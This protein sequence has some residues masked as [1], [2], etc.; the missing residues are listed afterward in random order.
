M[1]SQRQPYVPRPKEVGKK[2]R[3]AISALENG[4]YQIIDASQNQRTFDCLGVNTMEEVLQFVLD[5]LDEIL[6]AGPETCFCGIGGRMEFC[7]KRG[8][9][10]VRLYA[11]SWDSAIMTKR[12]YLK[13]RLKRKGNTPV[14]T[15]MHLSCH[16]DESANT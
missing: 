4:E 16:D 14:F 7:N 13:F 11:Y 2:I 12:M 5:F 3:D 8:F 15:Y 1:P 10:D 9:H 6:D